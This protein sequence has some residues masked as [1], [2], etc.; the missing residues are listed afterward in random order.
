M[1]MNF[2]GTKAKERE[3]VTRSRRSL[4]Y[5]LVAIIGLATCFWIADQ[6]YAT[7]CRRTMERA[8]NVVQNL[9]L[10]ESTMAEATAE[11]QAV[12]TGKYERRLDADGD[13]EVDYHLVVPQGGFRRLGRVFW[14]SIELTFDNSDRLISK[15]VMFTS[16]SVSCCFVEVWQLSP[17][18]G[19]RS[20]GLD[21][22]RYAP[23]SVIVHSGPN[24][25][26]SAS[27]A[28]WNWQL[29]CLT[30]VDGCNDVRP[31]LPSLQPPHRTE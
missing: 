17:S 21:V 28:A 30:S 11:L 4:A 5:I 29:S 7:R 26:A 13:R 3:T 6:V 20:D 24:V 15:R 14:F 12:A 8:L 27:K 18:A 25:S 19:S 9:G 22:L 2:R 16:N 23:Y 1:T 10:N 31:I